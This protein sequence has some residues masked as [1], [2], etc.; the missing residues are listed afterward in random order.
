M[1]L[2]KSGRNATDKLILLN[3]KIAYKI[4]VVLSTYILC[5]IEVLLLTKSVKNFEYIIREK[6]FSKP[7]EKKVV[8]KS[9]SYFKKY[10]KKCDS[11]L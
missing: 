6:T 4:Y 11:R 9:C 2:V 7:D 3:V 5:L 8:K 10:R 1:F